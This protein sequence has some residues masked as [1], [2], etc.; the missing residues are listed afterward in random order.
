MRAGLGTP[1]VADREPIGFSRY[2]W[3]IVT[4]DTG[5]VT[6]ATLAPQNAFAMIG[7]TPVPTV[8][9]G[10]HVALHCHHR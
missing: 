5:A 9:P 1:R 2:G 7:R 10:V 3:V 8:V 6:A 4:G